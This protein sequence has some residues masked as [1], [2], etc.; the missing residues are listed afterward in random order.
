VPVRP[1]NHHLPGGDN[2]ASNFHHG[3]PIETHDLERYG[4]VPG[5]ACLLRA[6]ILAVAADDYEEVSR[7]VIAGGDEARGRGENCE[8][9]NPL[10]WPGITG[11]I[12]AGTGGVIQ[13]VSWPPSGRHKEETQR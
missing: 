4:N 6:T 12:A 13:E 10:T 11:S 2:W 8:D 7:E 3:L 9:S 5:G 1:A